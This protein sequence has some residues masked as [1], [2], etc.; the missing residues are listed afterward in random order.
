MKLYLV[1][2]AIAE[3]GADDDARALTKEGVARFRQQVALLERL[4]VTFDRVLHSPKKRAV[5]TAELLERLCEGDFEV[6]PLLASAPTQRLLDACVGEAVALVGHEPHLSTLLAW[7]V[8][9]E[10]VAGK[11]E[12]KK[13]AVACLDGPLAPGQMQLTWV[14][15][16]KVA[17]RAGLD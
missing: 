2:H 16:P 7:L 14:L 15:P 5:D 3:E 12:L 13:G 11:V 1:R 8:L 6:T 9:G 17:R 4:D 10:K